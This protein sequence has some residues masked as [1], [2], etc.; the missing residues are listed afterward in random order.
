MPR[1]KERAGNEAV[2]E[3]AGPRA[4]L[5]VLDVLM[6]LASRPDG[7]SLAELAPRL[8]VPK[9][10]LHRLLRTLQRGGYLSCQDS[11]YRLGPAS[12]RLASVIGSVAP[13]TA[14]PACARPV[15]EQLAQD[16]L[17]TVMLGV[18]LEDRPELLYIDV[19]DSQ[20]PVR[21]SVPIGDLRPLYTAASGKAVLA[22]MSADAQ[23][24][25]IATTRF[26]RFTPYTTGKRDLPAQLDAARRSGVAFDG[27]GR[28]L[29]AGALASPIFDS[30]GRA[31]ASVSVAGPTDRIAA[32]RPQLEPMV[33]TAGQRIS[34]LLG[35]AGDYP[36]SP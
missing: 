26:E 3:T 21:F 25:Y 1:T 10:S 30:A 19:I 7:S 27:N 33:R 4:V 36:P 18:L 35:Y 24:T 15:I 11:I 8:D 2:E 14:F 20:A 13:A 9:T 31:F 34:Q 22:F 32:N 5:R 6:A 16:S 17:E 12:F 23:R 29:G 28:E